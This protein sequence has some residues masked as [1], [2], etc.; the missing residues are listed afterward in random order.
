[1]KYC[2]RFICM[3]KIKKN[4]A[5]RKSFLKIFLRQ[6]LYKGFTLL[7]IEVQYDSQLLED[8]NRY[9]LRIPFNYL[10]SSYNDY[11]ENNKINM[12]EIV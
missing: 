7:V 12:T 4:Q 6:P 2:S 11:F 3:R 5:Y 10:H 8:L 1:M 9:I